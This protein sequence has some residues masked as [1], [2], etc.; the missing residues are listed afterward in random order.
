MRAERMRYHIVAD[1][2]K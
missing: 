1:I 2:L